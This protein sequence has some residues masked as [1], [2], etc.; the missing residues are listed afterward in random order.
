MRKSGSGGGGEETT[1]RKADMAPRRRPYPGK[2]RH[3]AKGS[4][5]FAASVWREEVA[6]E[7]RRV[8]AQS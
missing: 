1:S 7:Y 8:V 4:S 6:G 2:A 3:M 5:R